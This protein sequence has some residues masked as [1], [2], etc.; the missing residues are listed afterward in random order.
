VTSTILGFVWMF[1]IPG[2]IW[3]MFVFNFI[4]GMVWCANDACMVNMQMSHT[5]SKG[6]PA[7]L[8]VYAV[9]TSI[10]AALA[11]ILG[12]GLLEFFSPIM[13]NLDWTFVGAPFDHYKVVFII[14]SIFRAV[15]VIFFLPKVWNEKEMTVKEAYGKAFENFKIKIAYESSRLKLRRK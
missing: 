7:A 5:P 15:V 9:F 12:G 13:K 3:P 4:G 6:R 11:L 2:S 10:A 1:A 14:S 8:A